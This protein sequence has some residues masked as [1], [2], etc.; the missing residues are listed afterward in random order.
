[1]HQRSP[2]RSQIGQMVG[3]STPKTFDFPVDW[4]N[5][6]VGWRIG[7]WLASVFGSSIPDP[8]SRSSCA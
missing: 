5:L 8:G 7:K 4:Q 3:E 1:M 6:A 2:S